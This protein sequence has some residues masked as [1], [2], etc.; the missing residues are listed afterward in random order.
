MSSSV[1]FRM[2]PSSLA[3]CGVL[4]FFSLTLTTAWYHLQDS[5]ALLLLFSSTLM[6]SLFFL[7]VEPIR[8]PQQYHNFADKRLFLCACHSPSEGLFL[9]PNSDIGRKRSAGFIIPN[10]GDVV[11]NV[12]ILIGG[13][14][15][16]VLLHLKDAGGVDEMRLWQLQVCLPIFFYST[17]AVSFGST[18]YHWNPN[19][20]T[21]VWDRLPMTVAF[22]SIF[23]YIIEDY[24]PAEFCG[25]GR[26]LLSPLIL[27]GITS[28]IYWHWVDD[29]R[30]YALVQFLPLII[31]TTLVLCQPCRY[32]GKLQQAL[33]LV[34]YALA[35]ICEDRDYEIWSITK[36]ILSGHSLKHALAGMASIMIASLLVGDERQL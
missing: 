20:Q 24:V 35:K 36:N 12:V 9:P 15:G 26:W 33:A 19:S 34:L 5:T 11:S 25:I 28:V 32:G 21:L 13:I 27:I 10:F 2:K 7:F 16:V 22:V 23:C 17:I 1:N 4:I 14:S 3:V 29:L 8:Q 6:I 30:L 18:Y 31:M